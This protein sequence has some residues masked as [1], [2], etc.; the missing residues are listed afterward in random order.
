MWSYCNHVT[1]IYI[2]EACSSLKENEGG[3]N[4]GERGGIGEGW[5]LWSGCNVGE[6]N[7]N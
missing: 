4:L 6:K 5:Q 7:R 1:L 3:L 2:R